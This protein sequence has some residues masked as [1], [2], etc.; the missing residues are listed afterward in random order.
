MTS[1]QWYDSPDKVPSTHRASSE[2]NPWF[3]V[4]MGLM[5]L[6]V[7]SALGWMLS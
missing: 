7:G 6:I 3:G 2:S 1:L 5:G 4:A